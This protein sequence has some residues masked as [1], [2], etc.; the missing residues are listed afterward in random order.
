MGNWF[1]EPSS[2]FAFLKLDQVVFSLSS[3]THSQFLNGQEGAKVND[4]VETCTNLKVCFIMN[5][6]G[7]K[8]I[9]L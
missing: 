8:K 3:R 9:F 7:G 4:S 1:P 6:E 2:F 5:A